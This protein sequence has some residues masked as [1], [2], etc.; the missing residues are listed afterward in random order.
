ML[1]AASVLA[2]AAT[3]AR[4]ITIYVDLNATGPTPNGTSWCNAYRSLSDAIAAANANDEIRV[5]DG[6][7]LPSNAGLRLESFELKSGVA[8]YGGYAG[9]GAPQPDQR[10]WNVY[11]TI[12]SGD[13]MGN[14]GPDFVNNADNS[15][16]VVIGFDSETGIG[17]DASSVLDG[18]TITGGNANGPNPRDR[19]GGIFNYFF[20]SSA[21]VRHCTI[22]GN[23]AS[24]RG[25]GVYNDVMTGIFSDCA[26]SGNR[27]GNFG[28]GMFN[29]G[30]QSDGVIS[31]PLVAGCTFLGNSAVRTGG[32]YNDGPA[33]PVVIG[34]I[35]WGNT[36]AGLPNESAQIIPAFGLVEVYYSC[37][38]NHTGQFFP[39]AGNINSD[40]EFVNAL[41]PDGVAG[42][43]DDDLRLSPDSPCIN[44]GD[45]AVVESPAGK[46]LGGQP[47]VRGCRV[48][49][50]AFE[51]AVTVPP[52]DFD[53]DGGITLAD[54]GYFQLCFGAPS[55]NP[56]WSATCLCLF[57]A[58]H[59]NV[60]D[61]PDWPPLRMDMT[62]P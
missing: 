47:R 14:D 29:S 44:V 21:T 55:D 25:G 56:D 13:L 20:P 50:G 28:G 9:C 42:T 7:Y 24:E 34:S 27:S 58:N 61:R 39:H 23:S 17:A 12:L 22:R 26:I 5:A 18:F 38:Q 62:G 16:H 59:N 11:R 48:D 32:M 53:A 43:V 33:A 31:S 30:N 57:D 36:H 52:G 2:G 45:P 40:P 3:T 51:S 60:I 6:K 35:L 8:I 46:D 49:M 4:A 1:I 15:Y 10:D 54:Y 19:G 37:V 41:G